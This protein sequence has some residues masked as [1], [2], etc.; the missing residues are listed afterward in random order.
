LVTGASSGI[1][2]EIA[3]RLAERGLGVTLVARRKE[4]L[5]RLASELSGS[6]RVRSEVIAADLTDPSAREE[7]VKGLAKEG[8]EVDVLINNAGFSTTGPVK[9]ADH[10]RESELV[11]LNCEAVVDLT[12]LVLPDM[13]DR[14]RGAILNVS[15]GA[16]FLP[17]PGQASYAASKAFVLSYSQALRAELRGSGVTVCALC[18]GPV[19]TEF[20]STA[21]FGVGEA[22]A[23]APRS[24]W[25]SAEQVARGKAV[26]IPGLVNRVALAA[27]RMAPRSFVT[28]VVARQHPALRRPDSSAASV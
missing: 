24:L 19:P 5:D 12:T 14:A 28:A 23:A 20:N 13:V 11:R 16:A 2:A 3:R 18:P 21:G 27:S 9:G 7:V 15:S 10:R 4:R 22:E 1:G 8:L 26:V 25:V 6:C 17:M